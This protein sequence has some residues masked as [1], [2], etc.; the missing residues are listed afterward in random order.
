MSLLGIHNY[1][2]FSRQELPLE[3]LRNYSKLV[4]LQK[5]ACRGTIGRSIFVRSFFRRRFARHFRNMLDSSFANLR[6]KKGF[7][8]F[9]IKNYIVAPPVR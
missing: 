5:D 6:K 1:M 4:L 9:P 7:C 2:T 3:C 8:E